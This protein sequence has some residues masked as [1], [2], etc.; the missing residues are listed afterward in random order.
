MVA[1]QIA[2]CI[3][4]TAAAVDAVAAV[5]AAVPQWLVCGLAAAVFFNACE[6]HF[7]FR[8]L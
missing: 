3:L 5:F 8:P 4:K 7:T 2:I 1:T 6:L